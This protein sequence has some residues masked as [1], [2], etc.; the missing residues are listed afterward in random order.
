M[1]RIDMHLKLEIYSLNGQLI[2]KLH[3]DAAYRNIKY[4][5]EFNSRPYPYGTFF[6]RITTDTGFVSGKLLKVR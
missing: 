6:Y 3:D 5:F 4:N 1:P 2:E